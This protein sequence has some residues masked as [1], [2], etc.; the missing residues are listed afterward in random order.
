L[1][2]DNNP[3]AKLG[4][5]I[6]A[7][8]HVLALAALV[9]LAVIDLIHGNTTRFGV[10]AGALILYY[11]LVLHKPVVREIDRRRSLKAA[12]SKKS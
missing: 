3:K 2:A 1:T 8:F 4:D 7:L 10:I 5:T 9:V 6:F 12:A 11:V